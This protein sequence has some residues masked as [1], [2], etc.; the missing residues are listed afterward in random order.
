MYVYQAHTNN[1]TLVTATHGKQ[2]HARERKKS[3]HRK[4]S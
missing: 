1:V 4:S 2:Q 3:F